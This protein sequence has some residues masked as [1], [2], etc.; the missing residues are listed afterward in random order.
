MIGLVN[1][2]GAFQT[3]RVQTSGS[4]NAA[5]GEFG[6]P[7]MWVAPHEQAKQDSDT[8]RS[9]EPVEYE[10]TSAPDAVESEHDQAGPSSAE[11][12]R[13][14]TNELGAVLDMTA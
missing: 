13:A 6:S 1:A 10:Q 11:E 5:G 9:I 7:P 3:Q 14:D 8:L 4:S 2:A 12:V